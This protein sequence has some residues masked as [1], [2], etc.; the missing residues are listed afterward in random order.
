MAFRNQSFGP[1]SGAGGISPRLRAR[2][3]A[4]RPVPAAA[5]AVRLAPDLPAALPLAFGP[6]GRPADR[7]ADFFGAFF[8]AMTHPFFPP[9]AQPRDGTSTE[10]PTAKN[11]GST[12][13]APGRR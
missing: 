9:E 13:R 7:R 4:P 2:D 12:S 3:A 5:A 11:A 8:F 1:P 6:A 10:I